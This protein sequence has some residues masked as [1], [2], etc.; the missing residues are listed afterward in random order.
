[1][2]YKNISQSVSDTDTAAAAFR[3]I[4]TY[5]YSSSS[6]AEQNA[7]NIGVNYL[8]Y[9]GL[10]FGSSGSGSTTSEKIRSYCEWWNSQSAYRNYASENTSTIYQGALDAWTQ[11]LAL[12]SSG[13][14]TDISPTP[15]STAVIVRMWN[16][17]GNQTNFTGLF[18]PQ[19]GKATCKLAK[20][21]GSPTLEANENTK[22]VLGPSAST[23][24]CT[25]KNIIDP[26]SKQAYYPATRLTFAVASTNQ[27]N[28]DLPALKLAT[29]STSEI[30]NLMTKVSGLQTS[31][32]NHIKK[33]TGVLSIFGSA[34]VV[35][36]SSAFK[37]KGVTSNTLLATTPSNSNITVET[38]GNYIATMSMNIC[39]TGANTPMSAD[40]VLNGV[41]VVH[42]T[43]HANACGSIVAT[44]AI[45]A[46]SGDVI[47]GKCEVNQNI[48]NTCRFTLALVN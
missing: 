46:K 2:G 12:E 17:T 18:Q 41:I 43:G 47:S 42:Q 1:M 38:A 36:I 19:L 48:D 11:C 26:K 29:V 28:V 39:T 14:K 44:S 20:G 4:C 37:V 10:D 27:I 23:F 30:K 7:M 31:I 15:D 16:S 5:D 9:I 24:S 3:N 32:N 40:V 25:R 34:A 8:D 45:Y 13:I 33:S 35:G 6:S 22:F 21:D